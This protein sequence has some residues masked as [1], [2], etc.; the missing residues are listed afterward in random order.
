MLEFVQ[1]APITEWLEKWSRGDA[2]ALEKLTPYVYDELRR[3]ADAYLRNEREDHTL[4][5]TALV[6]EAY[7]RLHNVRD[8]EWKSRGQFVGLA[9][10][11]MRRILV[12]HAR[13]HSAAKRGAGEFKLPLDR[14]E[15]VGPNA[16]T[17]LVALDEA[18]DKLA[19]EFPR[20][21]QVVELLFFGGLTTSEAAEVMQARGVEISQRTVERD[22]RFARAR[23]FA[24]INN[25]HN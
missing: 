18:L 15:N 1:S 2:S 20:P 8:I 21:A 11:T 3:L 4:Q 17:D 16:D 5:A 14:A 12:D 25:D 10:Q 24:H 22:W 19:T 23:L 7:L 6:H 13:K 9:A